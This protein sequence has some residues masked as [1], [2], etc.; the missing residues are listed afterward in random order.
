MKPIRILQICAVDFTVTNLLQPLINKLASDGMDVKVVCSDGP[1]VPSLRAK[2]YD[3]KTIEISR[4]I[5][6]INHLFAIFK[7]FWFIRDSKFDVVHVHTP[8]ASIIGRIAAK[9]AGVPLIIYTAHGFYFH[10][11]M[12]EWKRKLVI[13]IEKLMGRFFTDIIF[14]QSL[15]DTIT[16]INV[17]IIDKS[18][19]YHIGNGVDISHFDPSSI[20]QDRQIIMMEEMSLDKSNKIIGFIGRLVREKGILDLIEAFV[21]ILRKFPNAKL[22]IIGDNRA[23]DRAN[24]VDEINNLVVSNNLQSNV[25][26]TGHRTDIKELLA[27]MNLYVLPS[28]RE[29]MPRSIIEAMAMGKPVVATNIRG[30]REEVIDGKNGYLVSVGNP[31]EI[32]EAISK[33][34]EAEELA[35][36]MGKAGIDRAKLKFDESQVL[37]KQSLIIFEEIEMIRRKHD[38]SNRNNWPDRKISLSK[39]FGNRQ[40]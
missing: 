29:G 40:N 19:I 27:I 13:G 10:D 39:I 5:S 12:R 16:A 34:L 18:R 36:S 8:I 32:A 20:D 4:K 25:I 22:L 35:L 14:C 37:S 1:D 15:E 7:L 24:V 6:L 3:I 2:G 33:I 23:K 38:S 26:F 17:G 21:L 31:V 28:Y 11:G 9:L 30:C